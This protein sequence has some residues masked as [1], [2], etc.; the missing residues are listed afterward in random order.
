MKWPVDLAVLFGLVGLGGWGLARKVMPESIEVEGRLWTLTLECD[1]GRDWCPAGWGW[2]A[3]ARRD[4]LLHARAAPDAPAVY[5]FG[6]RA[7][8][9]P[10]GWGV[11]ALATEPAGPIGNSGHPVAPFR[12]GGAFVL[13]A[14]VQ[15]S[16]VGWTGEAASEAQILVRGGDPVHPDV[17]GISLASDR[18]DVLLRYQVDG[19][20]TLVRRTPGG[21]LDDPTAW[22]QVRLILEADRTLLLFVDGAL[23]FDSRTARPVGMPWRP[24]GR[25][26]ELGLALPAGSFT[27]PHLAVRGAAAFRRVRLYLPK[28]APAARPH[29]TPVLGAPRG[30]EP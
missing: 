4:G 3:W 7:S 18:S 27:E 14:D 12:H 10:A 23:C 30:G 19:G 28:G 1:F 22:H 9:E 26:A 8:E 13:E 20:V 2:G 24:E 15:V 6:T 17:M 16:S 5:L 29:S 21:T 25:Y 11:E